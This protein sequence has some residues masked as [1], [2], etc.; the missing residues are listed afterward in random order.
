VSLIRFNAFQVGAFTDD[1][2]YVVLAE[3]IATGQ[4][5]RLINFP[6]PKFELIFPPGWPLL[7]SPLLALLPG[8]FAPLKALSLLLNLGSIIL[9][10]RLFAPR[11]GSPYLEVLLVLFAIHPAVVGTSGMVM[12]EP[13]Y[14]FASLLALNLFELWMKRSERPLN[15]YF[16]P[17]ALVTMGAQLIRPVGLSLLL[18]ALVY[19][20]I[21]RKFRH[22]ALLAVAFA[23][24]F[25]PQT[26]LFRQAGGSVIPAVQEQQVFA[27]T[28]LSQKLLHMATN[29]NTYLREGLISNVV[30]PFFGPRISAF[31]GQ[32]GLDVL[33]LVLNAVLL[34][35]LALGAL[36]S[37]RNV[38]LYDVYVA[39]Y[40]VAILAFWNPSVGSAQSRFLTPLVPF[41]LLYFLQGIAALSALAGPRIWHPS[42]ARAGL[43]ILVAGIVA[44]AFLARNLR[45][46]VNPVRDRT[47]DL[48]IGADWIREHAPLDAVVMTTDPVPRYLYARRKTVGYPTTLDAAAVLREIERQDVDYL[49]VAPRLKTPRS[50]ELDEYTMR[51]VLPALQSHPQRFELRYE[52]P[53]HNVQVYQVRAASSQPCTAFP[54]GKGISVVRFDRCP[55]TAGWR[56]RVGIPALVEERR[57]SGA[58]PP[59]GAVAG[60]AG[61]AF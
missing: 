19:L 18:S 24:C 44:I 36:R 42:R 21:L 55:L 37:L 25:V 46:T 57:L 52:N 38:Q 45:E 17:F 34:T 10:Y 13:A 50:N 35:I 39:V 48:S 6:N 22:L 12:S 33:L 3:S 23:V 7:L 27:E 1:A 5:Y 29:L 54:A 56:P 51:Y 40:F 20:A 43:A 16:L 59:P 8:S 47:T 60:V 53:E 58:G 4:G 31:F 41:L 15:R 61:A 26:L 11:L 14:L 32:V 2:H 49:I 28:S 9:A 30:L